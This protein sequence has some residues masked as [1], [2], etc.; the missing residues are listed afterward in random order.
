MIEDAPAAPVRLRASIP[1]HISTVGGMLGIVR[2]LSAHFANDLHGCTNQAEGSPLASHVV[3]VVSQ[4]RPSA[5]IAGSRAVVGIL[6]PSFRNRWRRADNLGEGRSLMDA[7]YSFS[8]VCPGFHHRVHRDHRDG[9]EAKKGSDPDPKPFLSGLCVL[10][11]LCGE[12]PD[13]A[14]GRRIP[15]ESWLAPMGRFPPAAPPGRAGG[16]PKT[17]YM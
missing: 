10:C 1:E 5:A 4:A 9:S 11:V 6:T 14:V 3:V 8:H 2:T 7:N 12:T 17:K 16:F 13:R 15:Q